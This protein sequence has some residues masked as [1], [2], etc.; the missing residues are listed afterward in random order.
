METL[1]QIL[2]LLISLITLLATLLDF[3]KKKNEG[4]RKWG[5]HTQQILY[6][7]FLISGLSLGWLIANYV[8][9]REKQQV[10]SSLIF[11][12]AQIED[13]RDE[14]N[15][16][17]QGTSWIPPSR[18][19]LFEHLDFQGERVYLHIGNYPDLAASYFDNKVTSIKLEGGVRAIAYEK[20][21]FHGDYLEVD[22][23]MTSLVPHGWNDR[24]ASIKI[25]KK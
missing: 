1:Q 11:S 22:T 12:T 5:R 16:L 17:K 18:V 10:I 8:Q 23:D 21:G 9:S 7:L 2:T 4:K 6:G 20:S 25:M 19:T 13:L 15:R 14:I 24:I 3:L